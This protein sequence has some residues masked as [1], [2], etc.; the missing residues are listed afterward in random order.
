MRK[1]KLT[2]RRNDITQEWQFCTLNIALEKE[3]E[4]RKKKFLQHGLF[5]FG[6]PPKYYPRRTRPNFVE[7][8]KHVAV[9]VLFFFFFSPSFSKAILSVQ[10]WHPCVMLFLLFINFLF[11]ISPWPYLCVFIYIIYH[12]N[13]QWD[14][15]KVSS[16]LST[17]WII[18][19]FMKLSILWLSLASSSFL[20][21]SGHFW[22]M[23]YF[24]LYRDFYNYRYM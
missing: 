15:F 4:K 8:T 3:R 2:N 14:T 16:I 21:M 1:N 11:L 12:I 22:E 24:L 6:H 5:V 19:K 13:K 7:Q 18:Q 10:N 20:A 17:A 23:N 9:L